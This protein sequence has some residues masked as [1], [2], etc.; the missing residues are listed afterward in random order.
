MRR[1]ATA[2]ATNRFNC[3]TARTPSHRRAS[4]PRVYSGPRACRSFWSYLV[5]IPLKGACGTQGVSPRPR[6]HVGDHVA[7]CAF[8]AHDTVYCWNSTRQ[9][10]ASDAVHTPA[11]RTRRFYRLATPSGATPLGALTECWASPH[12]WV[13]GPP[14]PSAGHRPFTTLQKARF[15]GAPSGAL[16]R[17]AIARKAHRRDGSVASRSAPVMLP[18][19][20]FAGAG[21]SINIPKNRTGQELFFWKPEIHESVAYPALSPHPEE[22]LRAVSKD[23]GRGAGRNAPGRCVAAAVEVPGPASFETGR[24]PSSEFVNLF[25]FCDFSGS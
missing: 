9:T 14:T 1:E 13:L 18:A 21:R 11:F 7:S 19:R 25:D 4:S 3:Q 10:A 12:C 24:W 2:T 8:Q 16:Q 6:R 15:I 5:L 20:L 17:R 23:E 22:A